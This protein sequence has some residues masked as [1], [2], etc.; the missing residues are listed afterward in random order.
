MK[1]IEKHKA[2]F[3]FLVQIVALTITSLIVSLFI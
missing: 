3:R 2:D 1:L